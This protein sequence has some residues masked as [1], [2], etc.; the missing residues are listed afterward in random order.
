MIVALLASTIIM[1]YADRWFGTGYKMRG[2]FAGTTAIALPALYAFNMNYN[3]YDWLFA[4]IIIGSS[5]SFI[6]LRQWGIWGELFPNGRRDVR[7]AK[8]K[9][10]YRLCSRVLV[11]DERKED[12]F[13][14]MRWK[15]LAWGIR[16]SVYGLPVALL[17]SICGMTLA[18]FFLVPVAGFMR[19][20]LYEYGL[21]ESKGLPWCEFWAG[22]MTMFIMGL[23]I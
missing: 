12:I 2:Q 22:G 20:T 13:G 7:T 14:L 8:H 23:S 3:V 18:P 10:F 17:F 5:I 4:L 21:N 11:M 6:S 15:R 16:Y 9:W 19:G 1:A